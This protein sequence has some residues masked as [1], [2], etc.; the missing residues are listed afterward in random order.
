MY[1][2][3]IVLLYPFIP[4]VTPQLHPLSSEKTSGIGVLTALVNHDQR[5]AKENMAILLV[6]LPLKN[7]DKHRFQSFFLPGGIPMG[8]P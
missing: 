7:G 4:F 6:D 5:E 1:L 3:A 2:S 8:I